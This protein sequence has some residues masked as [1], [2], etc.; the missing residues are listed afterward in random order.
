VRIQPHLLGNIPR[1]NPIA[2]PP[3]A[4]YS[5]PLRDGIL[6]SGETLDEHAPDRAGLSRQ[7]RHRRAARPTPAAEHPGDPEAAGLKAQLKSG[8]LTRL[9]TFLAPTRAAAE[10]QDRIFL[11]GHVI[12]EVRPEIL[13][14][15]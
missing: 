8:D 13:D 15:A 11:L 1:R 9:R 14:F 2:T 12:A 3:F 5:A 10:C 6:R 7:A 4:A